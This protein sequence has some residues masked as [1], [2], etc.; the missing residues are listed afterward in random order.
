A[1]ADNGEPIDT[2]EATCTSSDGGDTIVTDDAGTTIEVDGLSNG[3]T[4]TCAVTATNVM[5]TSVPTADS[6]WF[7][8]GQVP[9]A[10]V[11][12]SVTRGV[13]VVT[14][15]FDSPWDGAN[16]IRSYTATCTS[17]DGGTTRSNQGATSPITVGYLTNAFTYT[18]TVHAINSIGDG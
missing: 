18:C 13:N 7:V 9:D 17:I 16:T 5:G 12:T 4:Y 1:P 6:A 10:P 2:Y 15:A 3:Y 14:V 11:V 8:A